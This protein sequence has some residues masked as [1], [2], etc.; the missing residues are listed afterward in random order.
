MT[1]TAICPETFLARLTMDR[2]QAHLIADAL[3]E[4]LDPETCAV[5]LFENGTQWTVEAAFHDDTDRTLIAGIV[6]SISGADS[7]NA[8]V[9]SAIATRDWVAASLEGLAPVRA[10]RFVVHGSHDR[11][12]VRPNQTGIEI[13]AALAFG[14]GHHGTTRGCLL[15]FELLCKQ[16]RPARR[17]RI[18]DVGTGTGLLA[19]AAAR[20][21]HGP[22]LAS[23]NDPTA[24]AVARDN[25]RLNHV[26][27]LFHAYTADGVQ[28]G[29]I[30][31]GRYDLIFANILEAPLRRMS[32]PLSGLVAPGGHLILSGLL[33][34]HAPG[35]IAAYRR[36]D[37]RLQT[38][39][40]VDGWVTLIMRRGR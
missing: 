11:A 38:R 13:E 1:A 9:F 5:S 12:R 20:A 24:V 3:A 26:A 37:L 10:G 17:W 15:A 25:A 2:A 32:A 40:L 35:I 36:Q 6:A 16:R 7:A 23:D 28:A 4:H 39:L 34:A 18:L 19:I 22:V 8:I 27:H 29:A 30:Q 31:R 33:P 21:L 14:T